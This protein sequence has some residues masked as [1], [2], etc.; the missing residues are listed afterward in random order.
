MELSYSE[1]TVQDIADAD[2]YIYCILRA[3]CLMRQ[4]FYREYSLKYHFGTEIFI[5]LYQSSTSSA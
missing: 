3:F 2:F 5:L 1:K 4:L